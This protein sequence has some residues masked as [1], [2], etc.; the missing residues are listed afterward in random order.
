VGHPRDPLG[1]GAVSFTRPE[2]LPLALVLPALMALAVWAYA[3]RRQRAAQALGER[4]LIGRLGG[5]D[6]FGFPTERLL[7]VAGAAACIGLAASG[8]QWG[9]R[10]RDGQSASLSAVLALDISKSMF[11]TDV[12]PDRLER[13]RIF[14]RRML[15]E[16]PGDRLGLVVFAGRAY[17]LAPLTVDHSALQLYLDALDP[18]IVSQGGSSLASAIRQ[19]AD[20][21]RGPSE[22]GGD[23]AVIIV[24]D[25]EAHDDEEQVL[26]SAD[27]AAEHHVTVHTVG[28]GTARGSPIPQR[29]PRTGEITDYI[30]DEAGEIVVSK[31]NESLL[32]E[33]AGR[34]GGTYVSLDDPRATSRVVEAVNRLQRQ[35]NSSGRRVEQVDRYGWFVLL[36]LLL[37]AADTLRSRRRALPAATRRAPT[38]P[39]PAVA[40]AALLLL[41]LALNGFGVGDVEK[42][43][44]LYREGRYA[45][46]VEAYRA[47]L[48]AGDDSPQLQYNLGTA[49]LRLGRYAEAEEHL[50]GALDAVEP[51]LRYRSFYNLGNRFLSSAR[52]EPDLQSQGD[53][54]QGA[55]DAYKRSLRLQPGDV[56]AKWN[57]EMA[58]RDQ[59]Q[60]QQ[61][62]QQQDQEPQ[63][64]EQDEDEQDQPSQGG[65]GTGSAS[66]SPNDP[67]P[68]PGGDGDQQQMTEEQADRILSAVEQDERDLTREKLQKGQRRTPVRRDW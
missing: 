42:G 24:T 44:R 39:R 36:A 12:T 66:G 45:E 54:L 6:L 28:V 47:A 63:S 22:T 15:R 7:L 55:V 21:A 26:V 17:V 65:R 62:Q 5:G 49:L 52:S 30:R 67:R 9:T 37:L 16:L 34:T 1:T 46:A 20:L 56:D 58:L 8:P 19:A 11:A 64:G 57:L 13:E 43:N 40:N 29:N 23:R 32:R 18:E 3:R 2:L 53:M 68:N 41:V 35:E 38:T 27:Y 50:R 61:Q 48:R 14:A 31:L 4:G 10:V 25:G 59:E 60:N 51:E 33:V